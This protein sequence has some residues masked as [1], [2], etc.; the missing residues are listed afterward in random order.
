MTINEHIDAWDNH[1]LMYISF[2]NDGLNKV[3]KTHGISLYTAINLYC[4]NNNI[5]INQY[6]E[7]I[8]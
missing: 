7:G 3:I 2:T 6:Y 8:K 4:E 5:N 1:R